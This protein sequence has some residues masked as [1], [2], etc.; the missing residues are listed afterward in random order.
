MENYKYSQSAISD[1][2][3]IQ[4]T[5][6]SNEAQFHKDLRESIKWLLDDYPFNPIQA[7]IDKL[8]EMAVR[9]HEIVDSISSNIVEAMKDYQV[10]LDDMAALFGADSAENSLKKSELRIIMEIRRRCEMLEKEMMHANANPH[11]L[12]QKI[13]HYEEVMRQV[14]YKAMKRREK[15]RRIF[16]EI[17]RPIKL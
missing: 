7:A 15:H 9:K 16:E 5:A 3:A 6:S 4:E 13:S 11:E 17:T 8:H 2:Y 10:W 12:H 14:L 1:F